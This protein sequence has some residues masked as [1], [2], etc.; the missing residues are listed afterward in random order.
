MPPRLV[1]RCRDGANGVQDSRSWQHDVRR[2]WLMLQTST[3]SSKQYTGCILNP[4]DCVEDKKGM[5]IAKWI[6]SWGWRRLLHTC[7]IKNR[8]DMLFPGF[9]SLLCAT[10]WIYNHQE[11][12]GSI[13]FQLHLNIQASCPILHKP[14]VLQRTFVSVLCSTSCFQ[15]W[16]LN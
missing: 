9:L 15:L 16:V 13:N 6:A 3:S 12:L 11:F 8:F 4:L 10:I 5:C 7:S 1:Q 14:I 2:N